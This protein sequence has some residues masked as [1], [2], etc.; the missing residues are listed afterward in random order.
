M[1]FYPA[2]APGFTHKYQINLATRQGQA[3]TLFV[4]IVGEKKRKMIFNIDTWTTF[5][6]FSKSDISIYVK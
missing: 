2:L 6:A 3:K 5:K 1:L 4:R